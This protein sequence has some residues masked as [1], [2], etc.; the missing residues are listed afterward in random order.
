MET[1][2]RLPP[3]EMAERRRERGLQC[4]SLPSTSVAWNSISCAQSASGTCG[5]T[6]IENAVATTIA[7]RV[8]ICASEL[9]ARGANSFGTARHQRPLR[10]G[11]YRRDA[12]RHQIGGAGSALNGKITKATTDMSGWRTRIIPRCP[13]CVPRCRPQFARI[14]RLACL[15]A[16]PVLGFSVGFVWRARIAFGQPGQ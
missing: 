5:T 1:L 11:C 10:N 7:L 12:V 6:A 16:S 4:E 13:S 15:W 3:W 8:T 14:G 2:D 9:T